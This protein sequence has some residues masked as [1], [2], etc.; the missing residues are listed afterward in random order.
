MKVTSF[1]PYPVED[2]LN[3]HFG[4]QTGLSDVFSQLGYESPYL[5]Y[6][7]GSASLMAVLYPITGV[8]YWILTKIACNYVA[9]EA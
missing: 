9:K 4:E 5:F 7:T 2:Q 8:I 6:N 3:E 1:E